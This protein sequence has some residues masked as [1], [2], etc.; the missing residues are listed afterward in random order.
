MATMTRVGQAIRYSPASVANSLRASRRYPVIPV[1][2][3][4]VVLILP[5]IFANLVAPHD[6]I[7]ADLSHRLEPPAWIGPKTTI[8]TVSQNSNTN[9]SISLSRAQYSEVG[10]VD[11]ADKPSGPPVSGSRRQG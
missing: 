3:M 10:L 8:K 6:P 5:S 2:I 1:F 11:R 7:Q 9:E 4:L